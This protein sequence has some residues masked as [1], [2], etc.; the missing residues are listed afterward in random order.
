ML[1]IKET[2]HNTVI[3]TYLHTDKFIYLKQ[4]TTT[5]TK[6]KFENME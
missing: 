1:H 2:Y 6:I 3:H 4:H 5:Y